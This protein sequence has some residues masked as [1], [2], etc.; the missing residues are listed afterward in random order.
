[1]VTSMILIYRETL[2]EFI[3]DCFSEINRENVL[4]QSIRKSFKKCGLN[5]NKDDSHFLKHLDE[6][7]EDGMYKA[8]TDAHTAEEL[9]KRM[10][11]HRILNWIPN[12][13]FKFLIL[14]KVYSF[15]SH[16]WLLETTLNSFLVLARQHIFFENT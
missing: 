5:P 1:M 16:Q 8:L 9:S 12:L 15:T 11:L 3:E 13:N 14:I 2:V 4:S 10:S 7:S 6:L